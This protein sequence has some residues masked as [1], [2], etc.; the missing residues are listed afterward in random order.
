MTITIHIINHLWTSI[1]L[2]I[3]HQH[4]SITNKYHHQSNINH[5]HHPPIL[6]QPFIPSSS[7]S[8]NHPTIPK[9]KQKK[10]QKAKNTYYYNQAFNHDLRSRWLG[11]VRWCAITRKYLLA[12]STFCG[13]YSCS[14]GY[15]YSILEYPFVWH[16]VFRCQS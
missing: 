14:Q 1:N 2:T 3:I 15:D 9:T 6:K 8:T 16:P 13:P 5:C 11:R 4:T 12:C 7:R 10:Q